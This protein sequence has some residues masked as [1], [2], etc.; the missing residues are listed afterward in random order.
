MSLKISCTKQ[1]YRHLLS[2][3]FYLLLCLHFSLLS[4]IQ[5]VFDYASVSYDLVIWSQFVSFTDLFLF[6]FV[7]CIV[8]SHALFCIFVLFLFLS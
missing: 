1:L 5:V 4:A 7:H 3:S 2:E 6:F 8:L